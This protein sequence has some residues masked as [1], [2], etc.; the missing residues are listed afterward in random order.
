M[1]ELEEENASVFPAND[2]QGCEAG[3]M[4]Q[5]DYLKQLA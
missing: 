5:D 3:E 2:E 4:S 1:G